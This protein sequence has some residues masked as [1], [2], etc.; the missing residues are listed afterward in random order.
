MRRSLVLFV[1]VWMLAGCGK[2]PTLDG[3][4][5]AALTMS[6]NKIAE[7]L[8]EEKRAEFT[9]AYARIM[10][11]HTGDISEKAAAKDPKIAETI[12]ADRLK[13]LD[14]LTADQVIEKAD[15]LPTE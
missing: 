2:E 5:Q 6:M 1:G 11:A 14:G 4:S 9:A 10:T 13:E 12:M 7:S 8:P 15:K 3:S